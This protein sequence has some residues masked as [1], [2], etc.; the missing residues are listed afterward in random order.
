MPKPWQSRRC[1][2]ARF[3]GEVPLASRSCDGPGRPSEHHM[4]NDKHLASA[5][6][7]RIS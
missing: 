2:N 4:D 6:L 7:C 5:V 3:R 1:Q